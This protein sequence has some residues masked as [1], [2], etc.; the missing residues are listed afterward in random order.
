[1]LTELLIDA[2]KTSQGLVKFIADETGKAGF[3]KAVLGL[4]GGMD[5]A[6]VA[7]LA[8]EAIGKENVFGV[9]M[10]YQGSSRQDIKDAER[11]AKS[12]GINSRLISIER[13]LESFI[14][15]LPEMDRIRKGNVMARIRMIILYDQSKPLKA[16]VLGTSNKTEMLLGYGTIYGDM[17]CGLAPLG[18]FYKTHVRQ[19]A[20]YLG[21]PETIISKP[22]SAGLWPGQTDEE[23]LGLR[24]DEVDAL[25]YYMIDRRYEDNQ[26]IKNGFSPEM[27]SKVREKIVSS[28]FKRRMP[29][30]VVKT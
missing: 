21:L 1:M 23:E 7:F 19:L 8:K 27:I 14:K 25:L 4:S 29:P 10:P 26:L 18:G 24:Y 2:R 13:V 6:V 17:A 3:K 20:K 22:P 11:A 28:E 12:S 9:I 15:S 16:L 5:S 30:V